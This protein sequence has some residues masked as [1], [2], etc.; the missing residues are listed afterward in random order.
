MGGRNYH[1]K[2]KEIS[3]QESEEELFFKT[4]FLKVSLCVCV[5]AC[6]RACAHAYVCSTYVS[7]IRGQLAGIVSF[8]PRQSG[9]QLA[10][11]LSLSTEPSH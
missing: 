11:N 6:V 5:R 10:D 8:L 7:E 9:H 3:T 1:R 2:K 4:T